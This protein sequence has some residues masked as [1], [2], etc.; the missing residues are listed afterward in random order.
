MA[1]VDFGYL[2]RGRTTIY[3]NCFQKYMQNRI[4][5]K[6][7]QS[8]LSEIVRKTEEVFFFLIEEGNKRG[9]DTDRILEIPTVTGGTCFSIASNGSKKISRYI[10]SRGIKVNS[11]NTKMMTPDFQYSDLAVKMMKRGINPHVINHRGLSQLEISHSSF[12]SQEA[13]RLLSESPRSINLRSIHFAVED[14]E[15]TDICPLDCTSKFEKFYYR[16]GPLVEMDSPTDANRLGTGGFGSVFRQSFH[17]TP[18]AMKCV[19]TG[20]IEN[21]ESLMDGASDLEQNISEIRIQ[22]ATVGS[23]VIAPVAFVRQQNQEQEENG[24]W[25]ASNYNIFIYPLYDCNLY[26]LHENRYDN[27]TEEILIDILRQ[28]LTRKGSKGREK[29]FC[30]NKSR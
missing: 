19:W 21:L 28:C 24:K 8:E 11:I 7:P 5:M 3:K 1:R 30:W 17:G 16:N 12:E 4:Y 15:C 26:E 18:M 14:I 9:F 27:L 13:K 22:I 2:G 6:K 10:I 23:G 29:C 20:E 25:I